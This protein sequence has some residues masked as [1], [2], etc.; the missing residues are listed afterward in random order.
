MQRRQASDFHPEV[1]RW[2]DKYVH[3]QTDRRGFFNGVANYAAGGVSAS[4]LLDALNP[5]I[6]EIA[7]RLANESFVA[8]AS[9]DRNPRG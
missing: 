7:R 5:H 1:L 9:F 8:F 2:F 4:M 3:G 6:E